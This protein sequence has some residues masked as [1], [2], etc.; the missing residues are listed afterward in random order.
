MPEV[1]AEQRVALLRHFEFL[2][3]GLRV[4][5][6]SQGSWCWALAWAQLGVGLVNCVPLSDAATL[7]LGLLRSHPP[8]GAHLALARRED[9]EEPPALSGAVVLCANLSATEG[10]VDGL[11]RL[12]Q[13]ARAPATTPVLLSVS[14]G[15]G[16]SRIRSLA[17]GGFAWDELRHRS[18]GGNYRSAICGMEHWVHFG[19]C[20][21]GAT[22]PTDATVGALL[23][24]GHKVTRVAPVVPVPRLLETAS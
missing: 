6:L 19:R 8:L 4:Y 11:L 7:S 1:L 9:L 22:A 24:A 23:G 17:G 13:A 15:P 10:D 2:K 20:R 14:S 21:P 5:V 16:T 12:L 3:T 18:L